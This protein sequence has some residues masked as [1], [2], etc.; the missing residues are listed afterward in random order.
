M[1][2][3]MMYKTAMRKARNGVFEFIYD[4]RVGHNTV[5]YQTPSGK[6]KEKSIYLKS[7]G[8]EKN[9]KMYI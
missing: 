2:E 5:R 6:W 3:E 1:V 8:T 4:A 7:D 9:V